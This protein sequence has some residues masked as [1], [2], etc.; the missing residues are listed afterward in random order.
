ME[1]TALELDL[2]A[3]ALP[4]VPLHATGDVRVRVDQGQVGVGVAARPASV[5]VAIGVADSLGATPERC[6]ELLGIYP[7]LFGTA[8]KVLDLYVEALMVDNQIPRDRFGRYTITAKVKATQNGAL[9]QNLVTQEAWDALRQV[10]AN[11]EQ[12][13]HSLIHRRVTLDAQG[14]LTGH[15]EQGAP[16]PTTLSV[17]EQEALVRVALRLGEAAAQDPPVD[18]RTQLD[19]AAW[20]ARLARFH[21]VPLAAE[22][23]PDTI[24]EVTLVLH[25][26]PDSGLYPLDVPQL[27]ENANLAGQRV[28]DLVVEFS[29]QPGVIATGRLEDATVED[30]ELDPAALP[31]W[32][33]A[34]GRGR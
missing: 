28:A 7:L 13:R 11:T 34:P 22:G 9:T 14:T 4:T 25:R 33:G 18:S 32:L 5:H 23:L 31:D 24:R 2:L 19:L 30:M 8:W 10:Y 1:A 21:A 15:D 12:L 6:V 26:D 29:D 27:W 16:L 20:L 3:R 17:P